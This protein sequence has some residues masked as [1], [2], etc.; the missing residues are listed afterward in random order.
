MVKQLGFVLDV[1]RCLGCGACA[2]ACQNHH[3]LSP[4]L[5]WRRIHRMEKLSKDHIQMFYLSTSC[6][7]CGDP[8]CLRVCPSGAY[9]KRRDGIVLH[10]SEKCTGCKSCVVSCPFGAPQINPNT[11][12]ASK[13]QLCYERLDRGQN[14]FCVQACLTG[15][16]ELKEL[17]H[18]PGNQLLRLT[19][20]FPS[21]RLTRP[22]VFYQPPRATKYESPTKI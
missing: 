18:I 17:K 7:H 22:S 5:A 13:C 20:P 10:F 4:T 3:R 12:K 14:P 2:K 1:N 15:A 16:L 9:A 11:N 8:E 6:N 19:A 21:L